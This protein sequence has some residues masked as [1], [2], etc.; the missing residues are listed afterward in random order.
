MT[1]ERKKLAGS[2]ATI[3]TVIRSDRVPHT[4]CKDEFR[5][6]HS[7]SQLEYIFIFIITTARMCVCGG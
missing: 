1:R 7:I 5:T 4:V 2:V 3:T 6:E